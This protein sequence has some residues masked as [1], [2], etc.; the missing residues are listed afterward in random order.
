MK[1]TLIFLNIVPLSF[2]ALTPASFPFVKALL[3]LLARELIR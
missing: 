1:E 3:A 2:N